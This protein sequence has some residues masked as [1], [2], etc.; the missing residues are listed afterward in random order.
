MRR[1]AG[2]LPR[3]SNRSTNFSLV[4][5]CLAL[6]PP[7]S[8]REPDALARSRCPR[9][10]ESVSPATVSSPAPPTCRLP[11]L[12]E[13]GTG[14]ELLLCRVPSVCLLASSHATTLF[15]LAP[16]RPPPPLAAL[17]PPSRRS[18]VHAL[19]C[20]RA[21]APIS[22]PP[23]D[24]HSLRRPPAPTPGSRCRCRP[25]P[26]SP[27]PAL[28]AALTMCD[29]WSPK[30]IRCLS[31]VPPSHTHAHAHAHTHTQNVNKSAHTH[32]ST[33]A[34]AHTHAHM[35]AHTLIAALPLGLSPSGHHLPSPPPPLLADPLQT[36]LL[37]TPP[38]DVPRRFCCRVI[39]CACCSF[40]RWA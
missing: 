30:G 25:R 12:L 37:V 28:L 2:K 1:P 17:L 27:D 33:H 3:S 7:A 23:A 32:S 20:F 35:R 21:R 26:A 24:T 19:T 40:E 38:E 13:P 18:S 6:L 16:L 11:A 22:P 9:S 15:S 29:A 36:I 39:A 34:R 5:I 8:R 31:R 10:L 14:F 4:S